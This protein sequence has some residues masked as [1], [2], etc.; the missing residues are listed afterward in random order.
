MDIS[1]L[2]INLSDPLDR[3][4]WIRAL[5]MA[6]TEQPLGL[7]MPER[8][9]LHEAVFANLL[10]HCRVGTDVLV[11]DLRTAIADEARARY[12][13]WHAQHPVAPVDGR[14]DPR[15]DL[16]QIANQEADGDLTYRTA[17]RALIRA[18]EAG[19][20]VDDP[21][22]PAAARLLRALAA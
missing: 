12:V 9:Y 6:T 11:I 22:A 7:A 13:R 2:T 8:R 3:R 15:S 10:E 16:L 19:A 20:R 1:S 18:M 21:S 5:Q 14:L 17:Q 4:A